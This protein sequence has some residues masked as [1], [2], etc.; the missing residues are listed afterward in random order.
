MTMIESSSQNKTQNSWCEFWEAEKFW[1]YPEIFKINAEI[2]YTRTCE[3]L[4]LSK[5]DKILDI[6]CGPGF[7]EKLVSKDVKSIL[8]V[9]TSES[10][11]KVCEETNK[12]YA[13]VQTHKLNANYTD[14]S[15][16]GDER[17]S[18][19][20]S[21]S[22]IQYYSSCEEVEA[23]IRAAQSVAL[24]GAKML[25]ADVPV[26]RAWWEKIVDL[27]QTFLLSLRGGYFL[28][29]FGQVLKEWP[30]ILNYRSQAK[31][32]NHLNVSRTSLKELA[33]KMGLK[34]EFLDQNFSICA[35]RLN[36]LIH[37]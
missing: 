32:T 25:I 15:F 6:G 29:L 12:N 19:F 30:A 27:V 10:F 23:L 13:N 22:V 18:V 4:E 20:L 28:K 7:Y 33:Q 1:T 37:F 17:F 34:A 11:L 16:V 8:A 9:D 21:I 14:L 5:E 26:K 3:L 36:I 35:N 2:L 24:P 31:K